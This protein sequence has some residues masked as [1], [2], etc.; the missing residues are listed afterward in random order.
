MTWKSLAS[1]TL[2]DSRA[3]LRPVKRAKPLIDSH[4]NVNQLKV[5]ESA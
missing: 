4:Q 1:A 2:Y 3:T 5:D